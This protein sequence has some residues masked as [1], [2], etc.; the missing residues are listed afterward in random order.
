VL[1]DLA[2]VSATSIS[3]IGS[4]KIGVIGSLAPAGIS[5]MPINLALGD[6]APDRVGDV[7]VNV[8]GVPAGW[9]INAGADNG[10]GVWSVVTGDP[11][12]LTVTT[13]AGFVGARLLQVTEGWTWADGN[14]A[15]VTVADNIEAYAPGNPIFACSGAD[16]LT[17]SALADQFVFANPISYDV[18]YSFDVTAD[19]IDLIGFDGIASFADVLACTAE[20]ASGDAVI[21]LGEGKAITLAGVDAASLG[22]GNFL[23]DEEPL[24]YNNEIISIGDGAFLPLGGVIDNTGVIAI[25]SLGGETELEIV[26]PRATLAGGGQITLSDNAGNVILAAAETTLTNIDNTISG[27]G[28]LGDADMTLVN[29][30]II[31]AS[32]INSLIIDTG[33]HAVTNT[34]TL[35]ASGSGGLLI[36]SDIVN[37]GTLWAN[38]GNLTVAGDATGN[39]KAIISGQA[40][41]EFGGASDE[42]TVFAE[43]GDGT[44]R[45]DQSTDFTGTVSGFGTGDCLELVDIAFGNDVTLAYQANNDGTGG[46][47][48]VTD[49]AQ[50]ATVALFGQY[51]AAGFDIK[52]DES[53]GS[54]VTYTPPDPD[55]VAIPLIANPGQHS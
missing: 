43:N 4:G 1:I 36:E 38:D 47:L 18:V 11:S 42:D 39:G 32:G 5:G 35:A 26:G 12:A 10:D 41:L 25:S 9:T 33:G 13:V 17:G 30:G 34:G 48:N 55:L 31:D 27:A 23:F 2:N 45:L 44:L 37:F 51:S 28:R 21:A 8:A 22:A 15:S 29:Q 40:T 7:T 3:K 19:R 20:N 49:G 14:T 6:P 50:S 52:A 24:T 53:T 46:V 54:I 16:T